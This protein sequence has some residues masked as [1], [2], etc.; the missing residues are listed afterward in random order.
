MAWTLFSDSAVPA[1]IVT[2]D[3]TDYELGVRFVCD[4]AANVT[5]LRYYRGPADASDTDTRTLRLWSAAGAQ[6]AS[7][8]VTSGPGEVGWRVGTLATPYTLTAGQTYVVSYGTTQNYAF[9][10]NFFTT[11]WAGPNGHLTA[12]GTN[13]GVIYVGSTGGFPTQTFSAANYWA[14]V[15]VEPPGGSSATASAAGTAGVT[16]SGTVKARAAGTGG[17]SV[18]VSGSATAKAAARGQ[19]SG[20]ASVGGSSAGAARSA[21]QASG[22]AEISGAASIAFGGLV[23]DG[24]SIASGYLATTGFVERFGA[25]AGWPVI[26]LAVAG[27]TIVHLDATFGSRGIAALYDQSTA[28]TLLIWAGIN[29]ILGGASVATVQAALTSYCAKA[30]AAGYRVITAT[31]LPDATLTTGQESSRQALNAWLRANWASICDGLMDAAAIPQ[32]AATPVVGTW[33]NDSAH[34]SDAGHALLAEALRPVAA[35]PGVWQPPAAPG[36]SVVWVQTDDPPTGLTISP[37]GLT[38]TAT[39]DARHAHSSAGKAGKVYLTYIWG[40]GPNYVAPG[41]SDGTPIA[42]YCGDTTHSIGLYDGTIAYNGQWSWFYGGGAHVEGDVVDIAYDR[43]TGRFWVRRNGGSWNGSGT[44]NPA[45]GTG[46]HYLPLSGAGPTR[47]ALHLD[48]G[49]T[50]SANFGAQDWAYAPPAGF[51]GIDTPGSSSGA[52]GSAAGTAD[53]SG[54][55]TAVA[56]ARGSAAGSATVTGSA[57]ADARAAG[58]A[59]G[60]ATVTGAA[61]A[62]APAR[63]SASGSAGVTGSAAAAARAAAQ[64]AG[65]AGVSGTGS[66]VAPIT[67]QA[68]GAAGV[69][70]SAAGSAPARATAGG[71]ADVSGSATAAVG[72]VSTAQASGSADVVGSAAAK[73]HASGAA[74]G[75]ATVWGTAAASASARAAASGAADVTGAATAVTGTDAEASASGVASVSGSATARAAARATA[76][77]LAG[78]TGTARASTGADEPSGT[79]V[80]VPGVWRATTAKGMWRAA[81]GAAGRWAARRAVGHWRAA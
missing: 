77:G 54:S 66:A 73:A 13:N 78:V 71:S 11:A 37:D 9:T 34:P 29:D 63:A 28:T 62:T 18:G 23:A 80:S 43:D 40:P 46:G 31:A 39:A 35:V 45:T 57:D 68:A 48:T 10:G 56:P 16:G 74:G 60:A 12:P 20:A 58:S 52:V 79:V 76:A 81:D 3:S 17:G 36:G 75:L 42:N 50:M 1:Q 70:G 6:L 2:D 49:Q 67:G 27:E 30:R 4:V 64:A 44:A 15:V 53:V 33:W 32:L 22:A 47:A 14:D 21:G 61:T 25:L 72:A 24:D 8:V 51:E 26:N 41:I 55:G 69:S 65:A 38:L 7:V 59:A 19:A 5:A